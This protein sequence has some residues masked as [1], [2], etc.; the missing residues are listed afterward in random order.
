MGPS[1]RPSFGELAVDHLAGIVERADHV[2]PRQ[3]RVGLQNPIDGVST[4]N[5]A[6][7]VLQHDA[8][9]ANSRLAAANR[10]IHAD[11]VFH[12]PGNLA[13]AGRLYLRRRALF[14]MDGDL[15]P[16]RGIGL[17]RFAC[18]TEVCRLTRGQSPSLSCE[19]VSRHN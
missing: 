6:E 5:H 10:R 17:M 4:S 11:S 14:G 18:Y 3:L 12:L 2:L 8:R 16:I 1:L 15:Y 7:D 9:S 13:C 19:S